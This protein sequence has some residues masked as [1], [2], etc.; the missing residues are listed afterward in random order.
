MSNTH[1]PVGIFTPITALQGG[2]RPPAPGKPRPGKP[3]RA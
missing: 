2:P 1:G 3:G